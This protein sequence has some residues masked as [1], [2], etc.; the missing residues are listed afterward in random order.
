MR[1]SLFKFWKFISFQHQCHCNNSRLYFIQ[2]YVIQLC[3]LIFPLLWSIFFY[4]G[5][6]MCATWLVK[7]LTIGSYV[8]VH[9]SRYEARGEF[10]EHE[11]CILLLLECSP[12]FP[13]ASYLDERTDDVWTNCFITF[14]TRWEIFFSRDL[15]AD[16]MSV[17]KG[18]WST[19]GQLTLIRQIYWL[20]Y[21]NIWW[22]PRIIE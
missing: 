22:K 19:L 21:K 4:H 13:S 11:R 9:S 16:V 20:C 12:N 1:R 3:V 8:S 10:G 6:Q 18:I 2:K 14:S 17:H 5:K 7:K 15:F